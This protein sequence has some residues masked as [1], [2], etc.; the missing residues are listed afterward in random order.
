MADLAG[1]ARALYRRLI[2]VRP[3]ATHPGTPAAAEGA[4]VLALV[5]ELVQ[6]PA[7]A[8]GGAPL[9]AGREGL[10]TA[11]GLAAAGERAAAFLDGP[12]LARSGDLLARA[13][14]DR[15]ALV[16]HAVLADHRALEAARAAGAVVLV[17]ADVQEA[18]DLALIA[19]RV[20][21][22]ALL[23]A[24]VAVD[25]PETA[26][27]VQDLLVPGEAT[28]ARFL[29]R[30]GD[31]VHP[32]TPAQEL[33]FGRH[34]R[35]LPRWHDPER[36]MAA[37]GPRP[38]WIEALAAAGRRAYLDAP[39]PE[40]LAR[41]CEAWAAETGR[42]LAPVSRRGPERA[43]KD[44]SL[45]IVAQGAAAATAGEVARALAAEKGGPR[46]TVVG[47]RALRPF[48]AAGL[49][50]FLRAEQTVAVLERA[51]EPLAAD[52]P[53]AA[54]VREALAADHPRAIATLVYGLGGSGLAPADL[55]A[56]CR[57]LSVPGAVRDGGPIYLGVS[58]EGA[59][60]AFPK[61]QVLLDAL[62][63][64]RDA[65]PAAARGL[66][67]GAEAAPRPE[68]ALSVASHRLAGQ[69]PG[70]LAAAAATL[71]HEAGGGRVRTR[72]PGAAGAWGERV[73]E[74]LLWVPAEVD[75]EGGR[76]AD[77]GD[78][79][80]VDVALW[81]APG[82]PP[83]PEL[84]RHLAPGAAVVVPRAG[85]DRTDWWTDLPAALREAA[86]AGSA[87]LYSLDVDAV[88]ADLLLG[89]LFGVLIARG[90]VAGRPR[91]LLDARRGLLASEGL[92]AA[93]IEERLAAFQAGLDRV[94]PVPV[95]DL[96][97]RRRP[98]PEADEVPASA[99][100]LAGE[101]RRLGSSAA[102]QTVDSLPRF[103]DHVG[104]LF[105]RDRVA[106][107]TPDPYLATG[108]LPALSG[109]LREVAPARAELPAF[110]PE[111]CTGCGACWS[112]CPDG[113][114]TPGVV[115]AGALLD[116]GMALA[117]RRGASADALRM[118]AGKLASA[119]AAAVA[120]SPTGGGA[121]G[122]FLQ[123][124]FDAA[125]A[126]M[127][128]TEERRAAVAEAFEA[129]VAEIGHLP[130]ARTAPFFDVAEA[131]GKG[132]G[133][134]F[135]LA[136][137]PDA[138]KGCG[139]C[140]AECEPGALSMAADSPVRS[141]DG[142]RLQ[143][144][145]AE[146]PEP[147]AATVERARSHPDVGPLAGALLPAASRAPLGASHGAEAGSGEAIALRQ[148]L[149]AVA[150]HRAP[151]AR[152]ALQGLDGLREELAGAIRDGLARA[153]PDRDLD[154]LA[155][156][157]GALERPD[158]DLAELTRRVE[159]VLQPDGDAAP[160][161]PRVDV[162]RLRRL[163]EAARAVADLRLRLG[164]PDASGGTDAG[165]G[166]PLDRALGL[167]LVLGARAATWGASFPYDAFAVPVTV[168][169][170]GDAVALARGLTEGRVRD[171]VAAA[172]VTRR[173]RIELGATGPA[174]R[175]KAD[176]GIEALA[177]LSWGDL[178][179]EERRLAGP[180]VLAAS[181]AELV[182]E[183]GDLAELLA[184][185]RPVVV[186]ALSTGDGRVLDSLLPAW[187]T[188]PA[189][190]GATLAQSSIG[191]PDHLEGAV[192]AAL[193]A[194]GPALVRVLAPSPTEGGFA[195]SETVERARTA[196]ASRDFPLF[197]RGAAGADGAGADLDLS[198]NPDA[199][200]EGDG[201]ESSPEPSA[202]WRALERAASAGEAF[203]AAA[204]ARAEA[205]RI[206]R[207][208]E[209]HRREVDELRAGYEARIQEL[210]LHGRIELAREMRQR[211]LALARQGA[212]TAEA[213]GPE[214]RGEGA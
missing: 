31:R 56:A 161:D 68:G 44:A 163:V 83:G 179:P 27:S 167:G 70:N 5:E 94:H 85:G 32:R 210:E 77:P 80:P 17:A 115:G 123:A 21:E 49:A 18:A 125:M 42:H 7:A 116:H 170:T 65:H 9:L 205:G 194:G 172:R 69:G 22:D 175:A 38:G 108:A 160:G 48:P 88:Q 142:R 24:V 78:D 187:A 134:L 60:G 126:K 53:L 209:A 117:R 90:R 95:A 67:G 64:L 180:L 73:S 101:I 147:R 13:S 206:E 103:W 165:S 12:S 177:R 151:A 14:R 149:G 191:H 84:A 157:L 86:E 26:A 28:V 43:A 93:A 54:A 213:S 186:L 3:P 158:A 203:A 35:R 112:A 61:R 102:A 75:E 176:A 15:L 91:K 169:A 204:A 118:V 52:G 104:V 106:E 128:L 111:A 29:G 58:F 62:R 199:A 119:L 40:L 105:R 19:R 214:D 132:G 198:G 146:L 46:V 92:A 136:V 166:P 107:L 184:A 137:D 79:A 20:A 143:R 154:A 212:R 178:A 155:L 208:E 45:V 152:A 183:L 82:R 113:A 131:A 2:G 109:A 130:V 33:L 8:A 122:P 145:V 193:G 185:D 207:L 63:P 37:G 74:R 156:G 50:A 55:A 39:V 150:F 124:A 141:R 139:L 153:L 140:V 47:V 181:E 211:L 164:G 76:P 197:L 96:T 23:P 201:G 6:G 30:P 173:A 10:A 182:A 72:S 66:R 168:D 120:G 189:L 202:L 1:S 133:E 148:A 127:P 188:S 135:L 81:A 192:A 195:P 57:E 196:V 99:R 159:G 51:E 41:A 121:A 200:L 97:V 114:L 87:T 4:A 59:A 16:V 71:L 100:G 36:P 98:A 190:P 138:C 89:A 174:E 11:L 144:L 171:A 25:G 34:R 162:A 129:V 110:D